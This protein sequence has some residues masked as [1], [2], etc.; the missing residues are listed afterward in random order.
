[1]A[2][3]WAGRFEKQTSRLMDDFHSSIPFDRRLLRCDIIGSVAHA[4]ML[5]EQG[6]I[7]AA[8]SDLIV[9]G[10][11]AMLADDEAGTLTVDLT[12]EDVHMFV[13]AELTRRIGEAGKRLHT[14]RSRNDQVA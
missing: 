3:L 10:L 14:G 5:G 9:K 11:E 1:M 8:D 4:I 6:V 2:K 12:A 7:P 13:E